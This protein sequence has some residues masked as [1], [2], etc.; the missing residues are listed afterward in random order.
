MNM[1]ATAIQVL[2]FPHDRGLIIGL[3][4]V[5]VSIGALASLIL[6][7]GF[8]GDSATSSSSSPWCHGDRFNFTSNGSE[9]VELSTALE[10]KKTVC[11]L[12]FSTL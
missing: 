4:Y 3:L 9:N 7:Q 10:H 5:M 12:F 6:A 2:N 1:S 8:F 11:R